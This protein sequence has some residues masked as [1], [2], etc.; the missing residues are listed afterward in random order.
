[1]C[2][3]FDIED[4]FQVENLRSKFPTETWSTQ[5]LRVKE[6]TE[7]I[8]ELL[9][10]HSI[11][12]TFFILGN[13]AERVPELVKQIH[14]SGHEVASHGYGHI[15]NYKLSKEELYNDLKISKEIL[16]EITDE[17][18]I[19]YRAPSFSINDD[20]LYILKDLCYKYDSS[21]NPFALHDRYGDIETDKKLSEVFL[22]ESG[23]TEFPMPLV[24]V[25]GIR[26]PISGGGYFRIFPLGL[27]KK[28]VRKYFSNHD[29]CV[30]YMHPWEIDSEQPRVNGIKLNYKFRHYYGLDKTYE[31]F[32]DFIKFCKD[33][34]YKVKTIKSVLNSNE[35]YRRKSMTIIKKNP[36]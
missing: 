29:I 5:E 23:I 4:W 32:D 17:E 33:S 35:I 7:R 12:A 28:L 27:F 34:G 26:I 11:K 36:Y 14:R 22:H 9:D 31:K 8:L 25:Y 20:L 2:F 13:I 3:S 16:E 6:N 30:F 18:V 1:M 10:K 24:K 21:L 15:L 19:G